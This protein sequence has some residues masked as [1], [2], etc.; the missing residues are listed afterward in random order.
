MAEQQPHI[1]QIRLKGHLGDGWQDWFEGGV[2]SLDDNDETLLTCTVVD[3]PALH[4]LLRKIRNLGM[5]LLSVQ[6]ITND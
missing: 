3:Q 2:I 5:E 1:Y 4:G 6:R